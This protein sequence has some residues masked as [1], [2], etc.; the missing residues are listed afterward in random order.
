AEWLLD[1]FH[2]IEGAIRDLGKDLPRSY[3]V[4]LPKL[5]SP[6]M[7]GRARIHALADELI[8]HG[9]GRL[10]LPRLTRF[11]TAYQTLATLTIGELWAWPTLLKAALV[12]HIRGLAQEI[13]ATRAARIEA[14]RFLER[15]AASEGTGTM[16]V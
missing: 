5:A 7:T 8:R 4:S 12:E 15:F 3:F 9:D 6:G 13:L 10:D 2:I 1:N 11:I 16:S 14:D